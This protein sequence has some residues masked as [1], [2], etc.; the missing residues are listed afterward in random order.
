MSLDVYLVINDARTG[1]FVREA[2]QTRELT[3]R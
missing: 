3:E 2:G 1:I